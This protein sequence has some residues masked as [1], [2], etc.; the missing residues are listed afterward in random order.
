MWADDEATRLNRDSI[1]IPVFR[2]LAYAYGAVRCGG[3]RRVLEF[4]LGCNILC[5]L[6][7]Q[8][9]QCS[10]PPFKYCEEACP[11]LSLPMKL[12]DHSFSSDNASLI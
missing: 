5:I 8:Q 2:V 10:G 7:G 3:V 6:M 12:V 9:T 4:D 11:C 1:R